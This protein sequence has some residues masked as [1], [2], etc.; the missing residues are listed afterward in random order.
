MQ[1][2]RVT[3]TFFWYLNIRYMDTTKIALLK[4]REIRRTLHNGE[5]WFSVVDVVQALTDSAD[6]SDYWYRMTIRLKGEENIELSTLCRRLKLPEIVPWHGSHVS[7]CFI[8]NHE[9]DPYAHTCALGAF[10]FYLALFENLWY[11]SFRNVI[12]VFLFLNKIEHFLSSGARMPD[13]TELVVRNS[14]RQP[15]SPS[16]VM[17]IHFRHHNCLSRLR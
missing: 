12:S 6:P 9:G 14:T 7:L 5:W 3:H 13:R 15:K 11:R 17:S 2:R 4:G 8:H 16:P 1:T 10:S